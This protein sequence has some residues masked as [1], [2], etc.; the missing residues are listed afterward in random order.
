MDGGGHGGG[1]G[2]LEGMSSE[3]LVAALA[4]AVRRSGLPA[5]LKLHLT[6]LVGASWAPLKGGQR[7]GDGDG[8]PKIDV[9]DCLGRISMLEVEARA[10]VT[11]ALLEAV[12]KAAKRLEGTG[13]VGIGGSDWTD[14]V[15]AGS[16][17]GMAPAVVRSLMLA[18]LEDRAGRAEAG[19]GP[20]VELR[21]AVRLARLPLIGLPLAERRCPA[22][23]SAAAQHAELVARDGAPA[24]GDMAGAVEALLLTEAVAEDAAM[25]R[26]LDLALVA[27]ATHVA[28]TLVRAAWVAA[29]GLAAEQSDVAA[30]APCADA[31]SLT[32]ASRALAALPHDG[33]CQGLLEDGAEE[34]AL[35]ARQLAERLLARWEDHG[36]NSRGSR[37]AVQR[38]QM[39]LRGDAGTRGAGLRT[40]GDCGDA[41]GGRHSRQDDARKDVEELPVLTLPSG[42]RWAR[43]ID[44]VEGV[45]KAEAAVRAR[46]CEER[47]GH[48]DYEAGETAGGTG[49][50]AVEV[51]GL[52]CEWQ[53]GTRD[54]PVSTVQLAWFPRREDYPCGEGENEGQ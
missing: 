6:D 5:D 12:G 52:D 20:I 43:W 36:R 49:A 2:P 34:R 38:L 1:G 51:V 26:L 7:V 46:S 30:L 8:S 10:P 44:T 9:L 40:P 28:D 23:R 29:G 41:E 32:G 14:G 25:S 42:E 37:R 50:D 47:G 4:R 17:G 33:E 27:E 45:W 53:P 35:E 19:R 16:L 54:S 11:H 31:R 48:Q 18:G 15:S 21:V 13:V 22:L 3:A 24:F 39:E